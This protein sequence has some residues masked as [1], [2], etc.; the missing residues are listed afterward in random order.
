MLE[1]R[2]KGPH[3][4]I[5]VAEPSGHK[6]QSLCCFTLQA[7]LSAVTN[8]TGKSFQEHGNLKKSFKG[9]EKVRVRTASRNSKRSTHSNGY[10]GIVLNQGQH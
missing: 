9:T 10:S 6:V 5:L 4:M 8:V 7:V 1:V 2:L 3:G